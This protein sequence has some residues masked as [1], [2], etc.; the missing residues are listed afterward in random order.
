MNVTRFTTAALT[1]AALLFVTACGDGPATRRCDEH[2]VYLEARE[3]RRIEAPE[4]LSQLDPEREMPVPDP[5]PRA[6]RPADAPCLD[7]PPSVL[8]DGT[9]DDAAGN[10]APDEADEGE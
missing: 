2:T 10:G 3:H 7:L 6:D 8:S 1:L 9:D 5:S 4:G